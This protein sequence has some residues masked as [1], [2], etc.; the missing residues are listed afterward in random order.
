MLRTLKFESLEQEAL[1]KAGAIRPCNRHFDVFI[2]TNDPDAQRAAYA[3]RTS[4]LKRSGDMRWRKEIL[5]LMADNLSQT[6]DTCYICD[7]A[8][9]W[10]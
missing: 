6:G 3:I 1:Y 2:R 8:D 7:A 5:S 4:M 10:K 9:Q